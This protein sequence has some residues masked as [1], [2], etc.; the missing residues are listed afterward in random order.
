[1][2]ED[3]KSAKAAYNYAIRLLAQRDYSQIKLT[4][5]LKERMVKF[6]SY[7]LDDIEVAIEKVLKQGYLKEYLYI[8]ARIKGLMHKNLSPTHIQ[9]KLKQEQLNVEISKIDS[10][11]YENEETEEQQIKNLIRK[12]SCGVNWEDLDD[13]AIHK[14]REKILRFLISKGH[15]YADCK[16]YLTAMGSH[17]Q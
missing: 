7:D 3:T 2:E 6:D 14:K 16:Q 10:I 17:N 5:K 11:F 9:Q 13:A 15:K 8:E 12:K 4:T 1:M